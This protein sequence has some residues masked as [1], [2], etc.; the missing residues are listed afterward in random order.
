MCAQS[1]AHLDSDWLVHPSVTEERVVGIATIRRRVLDGI[2]PND[3]VVYLR[4]NAHTKNKEVTVSNYSVFIYVA[5]FK[6]TF[7]INKY[8]FVTPQ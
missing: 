5:K 1:P 3:W 4:G 2:L 8:N 6:I 7:P